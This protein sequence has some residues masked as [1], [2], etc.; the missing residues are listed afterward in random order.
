MKIKFLS[1]FFVFVVIFALSVEL[2]A[3]PI[4]E[5]ITSV[6]FTG[7]SQ[8]V[9]GCPQV[10]VKI[11]WKQTPAY[12]CWSTLYKKAGSGSWNSLGNFGCY[13]N[14]GYWSYFREYDWVWKN[15]TTYY[16]S[17]LASFPTSVSIT[18]QYGMCEQY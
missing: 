11:E 13:S 3:D 15:G 9:N 6:S 10:Q 2:K 14:N 5:V 12:H 8:L 4:L 7:N 1:L 17:T 18:T 16:Y